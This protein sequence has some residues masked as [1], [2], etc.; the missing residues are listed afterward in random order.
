MIRKG[1]FLACALLIPALLLAAKPAKS[2]GKKKNKTE[3]ADTT[4]KKKVTDYE[5]LF[6]DKKCQTVKGLLTLHKVD[7]EKLYFELPM[8][9]FGREMLLGSTVSEISSNDHGVIG[10]KSSTPLHVTFTKQGKG[11]Q[12]CLVN[13][14]YSG[15]EQDQGIKEAVRRSSIPGIYRAFKIEAYNADSTAV[16]ID[17]TNLFM[18]DNSDL[19]PFDPYSTFGYK[20]FTRSTSF[21]KSNSHLGDIKAFDDNVTVKSYLS[22]TTT[23]TY[24]N[25][26]VMGKI[27]DKRAFT[28][29]VTRTLLLLPEEPM[30]PRI[31]DPRM[32]IFV[33]GKAR[34]SANMNRGT[35][36]VYYARHWRVE[37]KDVEAYKRGELVEPVKPI[38]FYLDDN[39]PEAWKPYAK[40]GIEEWN[41]AFEKIGFKNVVQVRDYPTKEED[42]EFDPDNL[43]YSCIRYAPIAIQN[44][45]GPSWDDPRTGEIINA[46]VMVYHDIVKLLNRWRFLQTAGADPNVRTMNIPD[47][48]MGSA[49][50]YVLSHEVGHCLGY[51]HNM[52]SSAAIPIDSLRSPSFTQKYGTTYS[53]MDYARFNHVAQPGDYERGVSMM[54]P[55]MG[56]FDEYAVKW[57]YT[58]LPDAKTPEEEQPWLDSLIRVHAADPIYRYGKQQV[59]NTLDP[60]SLSEDLGDDLV[61]GAEYGIKNLKFIMKHLN[62]WYGEDDNDLTARQAIYMSLLNQYL[63]FVS[64]VYNI[65]G[66]MMMNERKAGD[67]RPSYSFVD[68]DYQRRAQKFLV[69]QLHDLDWIDDPAL[70]KE[71]PLQGNL[72]V[73]VQRLLVSLITAD[74][75][76]FGRMIDPARNAYTQSE[77]SDDAMKGI[78]RNTIQGRSTTPRDRSNQNTYVDFLLMITRLM[79]Q[80][81]SGSAKSLADD[82][83]GFG[84]SPSIDENGWNINT[85]GLYAEAMEGEDMLTSLERQMEAQLF[86]A[87]EEIS[88]FGYF[89]S[90]TESLTPRDAMYY[91]RLIQVRDLLRQKRYTGDQDTRNHYELLLHRIEGALQ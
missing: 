75:G 26:P 13:D 46:S 41:H 17:A 79:P 32:N 72:S 21:Q 64:H 69:D 52:C 8:S 53:I 89:R 86:N 6:K 62:E 7:G 11:V 4:S 80:S 51:M 54:P 15:D 30:R 35:L 14:I 9:V 23:V 5:K 12:L 38:V 33:T 2:K 78:F 68:G 47:S 44:A 45:M 73:R 34:F 85:G 22:Y 36:P 16:V 37:P 56:V 59:Y 42:P 66:G 48:I 83:R 50:R 81:G 71:L 29:L 10:Y 49:L 27:E 87:P 18:E 84:F 19:S 24:S 20:P 58:Y 25:G 3:Q 60:T 39:L 67:P 40:E 88:G 90:L 91:A 65:K 63:T 43:K 31:A 77:H 76:S 55:R 57:L 28:A 74:K 70:L 1:L 82:Q 61:R